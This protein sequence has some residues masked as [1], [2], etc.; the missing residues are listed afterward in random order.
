MF[1]FLTY[2]N[3]T[4][5]R[6]LVAETICHSAELYN[7]MTAYSRVFRY[8]DLHSSFINNLKDSIVH[9]QKLDFE[10]SAIDENSKDVG[11]S[12]FAVFIQFELFSEH[13]TR[14]VVDAYVEMLQHAS[15]F[16][17]TLLSCLLCEIER[18]NIVNASAFIKQVRVAM[19]F[20]KNNVLELRNSKMD[21][22]RIAKNQPV[23][24]NGAFIARLRR[25]RITIK[26]HY[27]VVQHHLHNDV[28][29]NVY[30]YV[31]RACENGLSLHCI[32]DG[33]K[34]DNIAKIVGC[35]ISHLQSLNKTNIGSY[36]MFTKGTTWIFY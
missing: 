18:K 20:C 32:K 25:I 17:E 1:I 24:L 11:D 14:G 35:D 22:I 13:I 4:K 36:G 33:D 2:S 19:H 34:V 27:D 15:I 23:G 30:H 29:N 31:M 16:Y 5:Q 9:F 12:N 8:R 7:A 26:Q 3:L 28:I 6:D 21:L 10:Y